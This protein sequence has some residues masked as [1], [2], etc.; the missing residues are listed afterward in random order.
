M[1]C[2]FGRL[3]FIIIPKVGLSGVTLVNIILFLIIIEGFTGKDEV[4]LFTL[5]IILIISF[6]CD[7]VYKIKN[8]QFITKID[9]QLNI[10]IIILIFVFI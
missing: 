10:F 5:I 1:A 8:H 6:I 2:P 4:A 7:I 9:N 3:V